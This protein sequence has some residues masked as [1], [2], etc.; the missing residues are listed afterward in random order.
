MLL[1]R[2]AR[3]KL[4][5]LFDSINRYNGYQQHGV[6]PTQEKYR[7]YTGRIGILRFKK[8]DSRRPEGI[9]RETQDE[10]T[11]V[12]YIRRFCFWSEFVII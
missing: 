7:L 9:Q 10:M 12:T 1:F 8:G 2:I 3:N 6:I 5:L 11:N 4:L